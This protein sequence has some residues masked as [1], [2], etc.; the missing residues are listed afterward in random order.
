MLLLVD[1]DRDESRT[2]PRVV[3]RH[4]RAIGLPGGDVS[5]FPVNLPDPLSLMTKISQA[6]PPALNPS[7]CLLHIGKASQEVQLLL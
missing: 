7:S 5:V 4:V 3:L 6:D 1:G 2:V